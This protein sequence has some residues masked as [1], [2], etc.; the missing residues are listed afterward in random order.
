MPRLT[1]DAGGFEYVTLFG[2]SGPGTNLVARSLIWVAI[3]T[4][5]VK[6]HNFANPFLPHSVTLSNIYLHNSSSSPMIFPP[7]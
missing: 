3:K 1:I 2:S 7:L 4:D 6:V 5:N